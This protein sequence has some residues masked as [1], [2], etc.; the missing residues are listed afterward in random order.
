MVD[1]SWVATNF[2]DLTSITGPIEGGQK[3]VFFADH[4]TDGSVVLKVIK[5]NQQ[6]E[7][8]N[9]ELLAVAQA[10][11]TRIPKIFDTGTVQHAGLNADLVWLREQR[12]DG[13]SVRTIVTRGPLASEEVLT[14]CVHVLEALSDL[15]K[16]RIVHRDIKPDNIVRGADG[17]Y[18]L[19]DFGIARHLDLTSLTA[20]AMHHMPGTVGYAPS[21][22]FRN[23]KSELDARADLFALAVTAVECLT[24]VNPYTDGARDVVEVYKRIENQPLQVPPLSWDS[25]NVAMDLIACMGQSRPDCRPVSAAEALDWARDAQKFLSTP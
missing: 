25:S 18:W 16:A 9:R 7:R 4:P 21:E 13:E 24:G 17:N 8:I 23:K 14:M 19:L 11:S 15:A 20:T 5:P 3:Y 2:P 1:P 12:I 10:N 6:A 22:Q